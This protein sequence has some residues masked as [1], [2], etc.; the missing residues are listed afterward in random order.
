MAKSVEKIDFV[1]LCAFPEKY[2]INH[3]MAREL[4]AFFVCT[5]KPTDEETEDYLDYLCKKHRVKKDNLD[6]LRSLLF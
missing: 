2:N 1:F 5:K 4:E 6:S 3:L